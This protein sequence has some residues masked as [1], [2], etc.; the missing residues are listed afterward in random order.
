MSLHHNR[1][2]FILKYFLIASLT[3]LQLKNVFIVRLFI[4][5]ILDKS[6]YKGMIISYSYFYMLIS[7]W[8]DNM[9]LK[10]IERLQLLFIPYPVFSLKIKKKKQ[11]FTFS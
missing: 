1:V 3:C 8:H 10:I 6:A 7:I 2:I 5:K 4:Y 11:A 9:S